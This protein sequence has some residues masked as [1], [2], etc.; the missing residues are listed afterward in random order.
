MKGFLVTD[1]FPEYAKFLEVVL[2]LI[3]EGKIVYLEDIAEGLE[4]APAV[5]LGLF[6]GG[7]VGKQVVV[8]S[9]E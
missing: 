2:P 3:R 8:V 4:N 7:H 5:L 6:S 9:R 1:Y